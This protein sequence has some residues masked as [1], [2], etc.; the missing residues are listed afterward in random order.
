[1]KRK[2]ERARVNNLS[3]DEIEKEIREKAEE[4]MKL[5]FRSSTK[6][7]QQS[8]LLSQTR[9]SIARL[10]TVQGQKKAQKNV[11]VK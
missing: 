5:R 6:Q 9:K 7:L 3:A 10:M 2:D 8:H 4:S 11:G 1:M